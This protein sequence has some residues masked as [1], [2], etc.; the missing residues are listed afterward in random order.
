MDTRL[1]STPTRGNRHAHSSSKVA[2]VVHERPTS[3]ATEVKLYSSSSLPSLGRSK[4]LGRRSR[5]PT[6]AAIERALDDP[7][8]LDRS[9]RKR[10]RVLARD[11]REP[12]HGLHAQ[13]MS[14]LRS[15]D[16]RWSTFRRQSVAPI[17]D[18]VFSPVFESQAARDL[19]AESGA[20]LSQQYNTFG[21]GCLGHSPDIAYECLQRSL[22]AAPRNSPE[23]AL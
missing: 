14:T 17:A 18:S 19:L 11:L 2:K 3:L 8:A 10:G 15:L 12:E 21:M 20:D 16:V 23:Q 4:S 7:R 6:C 1:G 9:P 22:Y 5:D 13:A